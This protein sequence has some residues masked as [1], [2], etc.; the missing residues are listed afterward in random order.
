[1]GWNWLDWLLAMIIILSMATAVLKGFVRELISLAS[2]VAGLVVAALGYRRAAFWFD[3]LTRS[4]EVALGLGFLGL[5][6]GVLILGALVSIMAKRLIQKGGLQGFDRFLGACFGLIR[7]V[8]IGCIILMTMLAFS[9]KTES[10]QKSALAPYT[11]AGAGIIIAAMPEDMQTQF[12]GG[13]EKFR[14]A[15]IENDKKAIKN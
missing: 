10:V 12:Q 4:H 11:A 15:L 1:M 5:F 9:I 7:G 8:V 2:V 13:F 6:V 3:D 14:K